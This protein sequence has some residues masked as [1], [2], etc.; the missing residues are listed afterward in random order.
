MSRHQKTQTLIAAAQTILMD[1]NPM[2]VRQVYYQLVSGQVIGNT[3]SAYQAVS[4]ALV[5]GRK[6]GTIRWDWI[7]D[8][9]RR[10]RHVS[11]WN[12]LADFLTTVRESYRRAVW[13]TQDT[14]LEV[15]LE[16]DALSGLFERV[17]NPYGV[18][19]NVGRGYDGWT[20]IKDAAQRIR[21]TAKPT[22]ILYFGDFDPSGED[23]ARSLTERLAWFDCWPS[24]IKCA[25]TLKDIQ[26]YK[27]PAAFNKKSD[28]R[29]KNFTARYGAV[30]SVELDALPWKIL[31][32]RIITEIEKRMDMNALAE[33]KRQEAWDNTH[34]GKIIDEAT[35]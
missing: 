6:E 26:R 30:A 1:Q 19:L 9:T 13:H 15:W 29:E 22:T 5:Q 14:Y 35:E 24:W 2:T 27:L 21:R 4:N 16:K 31:K 10:P 12:D 11:M 34:L 32:K 7:E 18:T 33:T 23:M 28:S 25:L 17:L 20:S 8:R 3:R